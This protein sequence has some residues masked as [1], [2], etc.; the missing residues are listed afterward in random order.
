MQTADT[1]IS[2]CLCA[3]SPPPGVHFSRAQS[4][5]SYSCPGG[6]LRPLH[7]IRFSHDPLRCV[8]RPPCGITPPP[9][10]SK[11][12]VIQSPPLTAPPP[13]VSL[14]FLASLPLLLSFCRLVEGIKRISSTSFA[15]LE[16]HT[17]VSPAATEQQGGTCWHCWF[18]DCCYFLVSGPEYN[19]RFRKENGLPE[20]AKKK[21]VVRGTS[22][23]SCFLLPKKTNVHERQD[24][25]LV[26]KVPPTPSPPA[27]HR[28]LSA[29]SS[30]PPDVLKEVWGNSSVRLTLNRQ[31]M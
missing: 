11:S 5:Q 14:F 18:S 30:Q 4:R 6:H 20:I 13:T 29:V 23:K 7:T 31:G 16:V 24:N 17:P 8:P 27:A 3:D 28:N 2:L 12:T 26:C 21:I 19:P 15:F 1:Y 25:D 22:I 9:T 10:T